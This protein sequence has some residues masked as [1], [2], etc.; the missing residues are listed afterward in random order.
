[1]RA[2]QL[3]STFKSGKMSPNLL[4]RRDVEA[5][6]NACLT[7]ENFIGNLDGS[8]STRNGFS[9]VQE[10]YSGATDQRPN[11]F[12]LTLNN[13]KIW[14]SFSGIY[15]TDYLKYGILEGEVFLPV[16]GVYYYGAGGTGTKHATFGTYWAN[17][18]LLLGGST[19][20][21]LVSFIQSH[22][23]AGFQ[24]EQMSQITDNTV[25]FTGRNILPFYITY[26]DGAIFMYP[27]FVNFIT[28]ITNKLTADTYIEIQPHLFPYGQENTISSTNARISVYEAGL[29]TGAA[30]VA[31][32]ITKQANI[33]LYDIAFDITVGSGYFEN[34]PNLTGRMLRVTNTDNTESAYLILGTS[35]NYTSTSTTKYYKALRLV[36]GPMTT[37]SLHQTTLWRLSE[38][39]T[40]YSKGD[41]TFPFN[42][43]Y[44]KVVNQYRGRPFLANTNLQPDTLWASAIN[45]NDNFNIGIYSQTVLKQDAATNVSGLKYFNSTVLDGL[46]YELTLADGE[47]EEIQWMSSRRRIHLG[48]SNGEYQLTSNGVFSYANIDVIKIGS[49]RSSYIQACSGD[50]KII[51]I[52]SAGYIRGISIEDKNYESE[53]IN[54]SIGYG[55]LEYVEGQVLT[56][57]QK[58]NCLVYGNIIGVVDESTKTVSFSELTIPGITNSNA[59]IRYFGHS[60]G[61][62]A[63]VSFQSTDLN[64]HQ[65]LFSMHYADKQD[66]VYD[67]ALPG[68]EDSRAA[69]LAVNKY[70]AEIS[71]GGSFYYDTIDTYENKVDVPLDWDGA[72]G[73]LGY[74]YTACYTLYFKRKAKLKSFPIEDKYA[75][76][77]S[78]GVISRWDK[79]T[80]QFINSGKFYFGS[81]EDSLYP[82]EGLLDTDSRT[83]Q[84]TLDFPNSPA[85][86]NHII[87]ETENHL[88]LSGVNLRGVVYGED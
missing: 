31:G 77:N 71:R 50:R 74:D 19:S 55:K 14:M 53:D 11:L 81:E 25:L 69:T 72:I 5:T 51:Y 62:F 13:T 54:I 85:R 21:G 44:P 28:Y 59:N 67:Y 33:F 18:N 49:I 7:M 30:L 1:M 23:H 36:G 27:V 45:A 73:S 12:T 64:Y 63:V 35:S 48:T 22:L 79:A 15:G 57:S 56:W 78:I 17:A 6:N 58:F 3:I 70:I 9:Y 87:I 29:Y 76:G 34:L 68:R 8:I 38:W 88:T 75:F 24:P 40:Y 4:G 86:Q 43:C 2:H 16:E 65:L 20:S 84:V 66:G 41:T 83:A 42:Y 47:A 39:G 26:Y 61:I 82:A 37:P 52:D 80:I 10:I 60:D 32:T 46:A